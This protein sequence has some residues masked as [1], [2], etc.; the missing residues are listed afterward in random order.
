[1]TFVRGWACMAFTMSMTAILPAASAVAVQA[2]TAT[3]A[4]TR[5]FEIRAPPHRP[6]SRKGKPHG[7]GGTT[8]ALSSENARSWNAQPDAPID[9]PR[10]A[11]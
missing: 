9:K 1:M 3:R 6:V 10:G 7:K 5:L 11:T 2:K 4:A 8:L